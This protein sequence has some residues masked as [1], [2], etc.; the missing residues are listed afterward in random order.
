MADKDIGIPFDEWAE[1]EAVWKRLEGKLRN[2]LYQEWKQAAR[3]QGDDKPE[4]INIVFDGPPG[5]EPGRFVEVETDSG[6]SI[7]VGEWI[8][9]GDFWNLRITKLPEQ[10]ADTPQPQDSP[11][12]PPRCEN[13]VRGVIGY[14]PCDTPMVR[15]ECKATDNQNYC[16][17]GQLRSIANDAP[18][19]VDCANCNGT[20]YIW[21]C[22]KC[23]GE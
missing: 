13:P 9:D 10:P 6:K 18:L 20:G 7:N 16:H 23:E 8:Q 12:E 2:L 15:V 21:Q 17:N 14:E 19:G 11:D 1:F 3:E 4:A 5:P 22:P